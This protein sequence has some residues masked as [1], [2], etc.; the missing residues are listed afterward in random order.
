MHPEERLMIRLPPRWVPFLKLPNRSV[1]ISVGY[2]VDEVDIRQLGIRITI[3]VHR[4]L[5]M[6]EMRK[7]HVLTVRAHVQH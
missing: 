6:Y 1:S 2:A 7:P 3:H 5:S 4:T